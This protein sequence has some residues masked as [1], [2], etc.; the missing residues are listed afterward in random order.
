MIFNAIGVCQLYLII[1]WTVFRTVV[2]VIIEVDS[3]SWV[4]WF[5]DVR[6]F[7]IPIAACCLVPFIFQKSTDGL[8][9]AS[10]VSMGATL[11]FIGSIIAAFFIKLS[12]GSIEWDKVGWLWTQN[13][14]N[15]FKMGG[16]SKFFG[17]Y[18][19]DCLCPNGD[20]YR[21]SN[22]LTEKMT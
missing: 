9:W 14:G 18:G 13:V 19:K 2:L 10:W 6:Y 8:K 21:I 4:A 22:V 20:V 5:F 1:F 12:N 3:R 7:V 16:D 11:V 17:T 15:E